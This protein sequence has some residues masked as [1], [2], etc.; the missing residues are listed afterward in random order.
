MST[1]ETL[2]VGDAPIIV[3]RRITG[4][5]TISGWDRPELQIR[6]RA[7]H[8]PQIEQIGETIQVD[9]QGDCVIQAPLQSEFHIKQIDGDAAIRMVLG[10]LELDRINGDFNLSSV[11]PTRLG[12]VNGDVHIRAVA[13]TL[14]IEQVS[15]DCRVHQ[16]AGD[17]QLGSIHGDLTVTAVV[18]NVDARVDGDARLMLMLARGQQV[19]VETHGDLNCLVPTDASL[20]AEL[21]ANGDIRVKHLGDAPRARHGT[22]SVVTGD[23]AALLNLKASGDLRLIGTDAHLRGAEFGFDPEVSEEMSRRATELSQQITEQVESQVNAFSRELEEKL[24]RMGNDEEMANKIQERV[25]SALRKAEEKMAEAMRKVEIRSQEAER[26]AYEQD[27]RRRKGY[28]WQTPPTPPMP[29]APPPPAAPKRSAATDEERMIILR[30]VE[31]GKI[32]IDQAEKLLA[33][34]NGNR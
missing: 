17:A 28:A 23:G 8:D 14:Q 6:G 16:I 33:A 7:R 24:S 3:L 31:Q 18:G 11:G 4:D 29:S 2:T 34:L 10:A 12:Q 19:T 13:G 20:R 27:N 15:G 1:L 9:T 5:L 21:E 32:S 26:R 30:M 25:T 22:L